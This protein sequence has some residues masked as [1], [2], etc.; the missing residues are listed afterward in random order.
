LGI[1]VWQYYWIGGV[2]E[3]V[4]FPGDASDG[5]N[6]IS[7]LIGPRGFFTPIYRV[8]D[9]VIELRRQCGDFLLADRLTYNFRKPARGEIVVFKTQGIPEEGRARYTIPEGEFYL[10]RLVGLPDET[11]QIG[12]DRHLII[13]GQRLDASTPHFAK[14]YGFNPRQAPA[15]QKYSGH[16]NGAMIE[17]YGMRSDFP[18]MFPDAQAAYTNGPGMYLV[19]GDNTVDSL[20]SRYWGAITQDAIIGKCWFVFWPL[21]ERFGWQGDR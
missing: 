16:L 1:N 15:Q 17:H 20:D 8:G 10:K 19:M 11:V 4:W 9:K 5:R 3:R 13:D 12:D 14:V 2:R 6:G 21:T 7:S 18:I